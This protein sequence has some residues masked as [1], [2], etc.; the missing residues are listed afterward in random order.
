MIWEIEKSVSGLGV[1]SELGL[2]FYYGK[3]PDIAGIK[4]DPGHPLYD[5][6]HDL[7]DIYSALHTLFA[8]P[9]Y[10]DEKGVE[11]DFDPWRSA[12]SGHLEPISA[13][14]VNDAR[15]HM[16]VMLNH[17]NL[18]PPPFGTKDENKTGLSF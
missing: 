9:T 5:D 12:E 11:R 2:R 16:A 13:S 15:K 3:Y 6:F 4:A 18:C 17:G 10:K 8:V 1:N 7:P 14:S